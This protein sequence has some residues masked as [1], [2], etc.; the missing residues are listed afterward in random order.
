MSHFIDQDPI[1][2]GRNGDVSL[3][4]RSYIS[5]SGS[6]WDSINLI[7][8]SSTA[9]PE[10]LRLNV[11]LPVAKAEHLRDRLSAAIVAARG[12]QP[13]DDEAANE[14]VSDIDIAPGSITFPHDPSPFD[15][16]EF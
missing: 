1:F 10:E 14:P 6:E 12:D 8:G 11:N 13:P 4:V 15:E 7:V 3:V 9:Y 2:I 16:I 5:D